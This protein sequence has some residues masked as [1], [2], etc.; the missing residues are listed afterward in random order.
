MTAWMLAL[1][2]L[3]ACKSGGGSAARGGPAGAGS[4]APPLPAAGS[5]AQAASF[6]RS[7][8]P[9]GVG[10]LTA[11]TDSRTAASLFPGMTAK[12]EH[13][14]AEDYS[15][16]DITISDRA[17]GDPVLHVVIDNMRAARS[18]FRVDVV[19]PMFATP[20]GI[21]VG[22]SV[23]D[24]AAAYPDAACTRATYTE[25]PEGF[26]RALSCESASLS[27]LSFH[28]DPDALSGPDGKV[29]VAKL[30]PFRIDRI[31]WLPARP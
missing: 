26:D 13:S 20:K 8:T 17:G 6:S 22:S 25:N 14:E 15:F 27:N 29:A 7:I 3:V 9:D 2:M 4:A 12:T 16:D 28:V 21:R 19:G 23:G 10:P 5:S 24:L 30:A 11:A 1:T 18:I 31:I